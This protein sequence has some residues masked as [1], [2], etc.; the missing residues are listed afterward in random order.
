MPTMHN[1]DYVASVWDVLVAECGARES[2]RQD[3]MH[4]WPKCVEY[5]FCGSL[6]FGGKVWSNNGRVYVSC[7]QEDET[8]ERRAL[9]DQTNARLDAL[10]IDGTGEPHAGG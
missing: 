5:R 10:L 9:V 8:P 3:F 6:G 4:H 1:A 7:Y 2:E